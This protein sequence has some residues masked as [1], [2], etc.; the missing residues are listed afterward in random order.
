MST[1]SLV[2]K[3][4]CLNPQVKTPSARKEAKHRPTPIFSHFR[5][6]LSQLRLYLLSTTLKFLH[7]VHAETQLSLYF[8]DTLKTPY[9]N[10]TA[11]EIHV[12]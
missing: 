9:G 3:P 6:G 4:A 12:L 1:A 8:G 10:L 7:T 11:T 5:T 2:L